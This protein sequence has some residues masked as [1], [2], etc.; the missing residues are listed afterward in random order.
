M[1]KDPL[2][3]INTLSNN[4]IDHNFS[5][6]QTGPQKDPEIQYGFPHCWRIRWIRQFFDHV[7]CVDKSN[8]PENNYQAK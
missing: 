8:N 5:N 1:N 2:S 6:Q 4:P 7:K 3:V